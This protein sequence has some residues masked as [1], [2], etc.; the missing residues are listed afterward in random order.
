MCNKLNVPFVKTQKL[1]DINNCKDFP[2]V[3]K[4]SISASGDN[5]FKIDTFMQ[6]KS[7]IDNNRITNLNDNFFLIQPFIEGI[8]NGEK[9]YIFINGCCKYAVNRFPG[10]F[11]SEKNIEVLDLKDVD[12]QIISYGKTIYNYFNKN[13]THFRLDIVY[14]NN[15]P[16]IMEIETIDPDLFIRNIEDQNLKENVIEELSSIIV[17]KILKEYN[18]IKHD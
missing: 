10:I 12:N 5:T 13:I 8:Y 18:N 4:P 15:Q 3:I 11:T 14:Q 9:S 16:L 6:L 17:N 1:D 2:I 7:F